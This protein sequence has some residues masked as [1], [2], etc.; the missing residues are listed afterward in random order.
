[1]TI[2]IKKKAMNIENSTVLMTGTLCVSRA[3]AP[4]QPTMAA[5]R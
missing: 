3:F 4:A 5:V 2:I 1:M